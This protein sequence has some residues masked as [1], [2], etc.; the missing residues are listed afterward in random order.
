MPRAV[1]F[2]MD[3]VLAFTEPYYR[4]RRLDYLADNGV[5]LTGEP[6]WTGMH[7]D[8]TWRACVPD[9]APRRERLRAGYE[10]YARTRPTPWQEL[11][12]PQA[13]GVFEK[14]RD[15]G[16]ATAICSSSP[17]ESVDECVRALRVGALVTYVISGDECAGHKPDPE[18][19]LRAMDALAV[20]PLDSV[21]VEDSSIGIEAGRRAGALVCG[22]RQP[23]DPQPDQSAANLVLSELGEVLELFE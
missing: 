3:G 9:D 6:D 14:L 1:L 18:I 2:D 16:V 19:Y 5:A 13:R 15:L 8:D 4:Q 7:D 12:N 17:R 21:V 23:T 11:I 22:L 20:S 10:R